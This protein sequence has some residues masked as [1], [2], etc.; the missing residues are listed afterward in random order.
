MTASA[1]QGRVGDSQ[2]QALNRW[3][4]RN[5]ERGST[6][7]ISAGRQVTTWSRHNEFDFT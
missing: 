1:S 7:S 2:L 3:A 4:G 6:Q 5:K